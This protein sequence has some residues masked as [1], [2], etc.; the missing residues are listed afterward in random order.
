MSLSYGAI[1]LASILEFTCGALWYTVLFGKSWREIHHIDKLSKAQQEELMKGM[2]GIYALQFL[3]TVISTAVLAFFIS[4]LTVDQTFLVAGL[5]WLGFVLPTQVSAVL[6][7]GTEK[8]M[9]AKKIAIMSGGTL[10][11]LLIAAAVLRSF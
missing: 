7:G 3:I 5:C 2:G 8:G 6:F 10:L 11:C 1:L 4:Q 9:R